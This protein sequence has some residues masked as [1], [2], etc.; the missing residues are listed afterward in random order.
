MAPARPAAP[1]DACLAEAL[2][3]G[4]EWV[5]HWLTQLNEALANGEDG[6]ETL[7]EKQ[8]YIR[9]RTSL[10]G[11]RER[12]ATRLL[13]VLSESI[14][15][16]A[17]GT[18]VTA[19]VHPA[20][21]R[22]LKGLSM[23]DLTLMDDDRVQQT[24][25]LTR[26][27]QAVKQG[28]ED[29]LME[30]NARLCNARG[31]D[32]VREQVNPLRPEKVV[33]A[34]LETLDSLYLPPGVRALWLNTGAALLGHEL[35]QLYRH[36]SG[37]LDGWGVT[38]AAFTVIQSPQ[39]RRAAAEPPAAPP[40][41]RAESVPAEAMRGGDSQLT[42]DHLQE[43]LQGNLASTGHGAS[44]HGTSGSGNAMVKTLA[45][46]VVT[47]M[48]KRVSEDKRLLGS[49]REQ[50]AGLKPALQLLARSDPRYF[51]DPANP[52]RRL[53]DV[54]AARGKAFRTEQDAGYVAFADAVHGIVRATRA[55]VSEWVR[56]VP[57]WVALLERVPATAPESAQR[58][59]HHP[60]RDQMALQ[61]ATEFRAREDFARVPGV[62]RR[63]LCG[64][65]AQV[66]A[67]ARLDDASGLRDGS[68]LRYT[69]ILTDLLWSCQLALASRNRPRLI[70]LVPT[71]LRT[72]REGLDSIDYPREEAEAFFHAL[73][74]L[75][76]AAY[77]TLL[78]EQPVNP[79]VAILSQAMTD[80]H[81]DPASDAVELEVA[82][83]EFSDT[84]PMEPL[85]ALAPAVPADLSVLGL[86]VGAW[87]DL[88]HE[89]EPVR[90][91]LS[92]ASPHGTVFLF[93]M[94]SGRSL[95]LTRHGIK[96][97][98]A[99]DR[100]RVLQNPELR[101]DVDGD[102]DRQAWIDSIRMVSA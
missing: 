52:V 67:Q 9:A 29:S 19:S 81:P 63:F 76:D 40:S 75:Q 61:L 30:F 33:S 50:V 100:M 101:A 71:V 8:V 15:V 64:P 83:P 48:L 88:W 55:P 66:V 5:P 57:Q 95:S 27:H 99:Q 47:L 56:C 79:P 82:Q 22:P 21:T 20:P 39:P 93:T 23:D 96:S 54:C 59:E 37:M 14:R 85:K 32:L 31:L 70:R 38:P 73:L 86:A 43:L 4:R 87:V 25:D 6:A 28:A 12:I 84:V 94:A 7:N 65:W 41:A 36:L 46:E 49:L 16:D 74:G 1:F 69:D 26:V 51:A 77:K 78:D 90:C 11:F 58:S 45:S 60:D 102:P 10:V 68:A 53:F 18:P 17:G 72:L 42:L 24:V 98:Q 62:V 92:R 2:A 91:R 80:H 13:E 89:G 34:L 97:L 35:H 3:L 44:D